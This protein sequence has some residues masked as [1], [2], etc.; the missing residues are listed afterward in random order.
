MVRSVARDSG[1]PALKIVPDTDL[2]R[3]IEANMIKRGSL[4]AIEAAPS[5]LE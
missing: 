4:T 2:Q 5:I 1:V 3:N